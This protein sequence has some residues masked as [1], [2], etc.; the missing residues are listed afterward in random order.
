MS[1]AKEK[2]KEK[3]TKHWFFGAK[4]VI[5]GFVLF[6]LV[7]SLIMPAILYP[8]TTKAQG[9]LGIPVTDPG[10][11]AVEEEKGIWQKAWEA[12]KKAKDEATQ[13]LK[14]VV[15]VALNQSL[16]N[17]LNTLAYDVATW[18]ASGGEGQKPM[19]FT[20]GWG[21]YLKNLADGAA[22]EF[23]EELSGS[24][25]GFNVCNP[26]STNLK[27]R[28]GLGLTETKR[29]KT[30]DCSVTDMIN[31]WSSAVND[32]DFLPKFSD[33]FDPY[34]NDIGIAISMFGK[35][36]EIEADAVEAGT[37]DREEGQGF[38]GKISKIAGKILTPHLLSKEQAAKLTQ[39]DEGEAS[40]VHWGSITLEAVETFIN[41]LAGKMFERLFKEG[42]ATGDSSSDSSGQF[43]GLSL[44]SLRGLLLNSRATTQELYTGEMGAQGFA[45]QERAELRFTD[46][47]QVGVKGQKP[48]DILS[49]LA[50]CPDPEN[51]G[52]EECVIRSDFRLAI[53]KELTLQEAIDQG[54]VNGDAPFGFDE[55]DND[56]IF[57]GYPYRSIVIL[58]T[59]R[60]VPV[61][62]E[63]ASQMINN[64]EIAKTEPTDTFTLNKLIDKFDDSESIFHGL[65]DPNWVLK[66]PE[67]FCRA[68]GFGEK[69]M[70]EELSGGSDGNGDGD[71]EDPQDTLPSR[72]IGRAEYCADFQTC[73]AEDYD[74]SCNYY[75]YCSEEKRVWNL[76]G[77]TCPEE[78]NT[79]RTFQSSSGGIFSYLENSLEYNNCNADNAGCQWYCQA[80]STIDNLW[81]CTYDNEKTLK[82]CTQ[83]GGCTV[84][85]NC[86]VPA[87]QNYCDGSNSVVNLTMGEPCSQTSQWWNGTACALNFSCTIPQNGVSCTKTG[88]ES[89]SNLLANSS[90]ETGV[91]P[92]LPAEADKYLAAD[93][94]TDETGLAYWDLVSGVNER[95]YPPGT[96]INSIRFFS[97]GTD[98]LTSGTSLKSDKLTLPADNYTFS[99]YIY[100]HLNLGTITLS[101]RQSDGSLIVEKDFD[102][103]KINQWQELSADFTISGGEIFVQAKV[104]GSYVSGTAWIDNFQ[105]AKN[106]AATPVVLTLVGDVETD[107]SKLHLDRDAE[108]CEEDASGCSELIRTKANLGT[109]LVPNSSFEDWPNPIDLPSGWQKGEEWV[110][111]SISRE[112]E[113]AVGNF[114]LKLTSD[115]NLNNPRKFETAPLTGLKANT[116]YQVSFYAK[117]A[118]GESITSAEGIWYTEILS[119]HNPENYCSLNPTISCTPSPDSCAAAGRGVC[120]TDYQHLIS[121]GSNSIYFGLSDSWQRIVME[122]ITTRRYGTD[123]K[124]SFTSGSTVI[125]KPLYID[126]VQIEE[127][128]TN[129][130][131]TSNYT[132]YGTT[133][134]TYLKKA[135]DYLNCLGYTYNRPSPYYL[136]KVTK[137]QCAGDNLMWSDACDSSGTYCCHEID[138]P[139]CFDYALYCQED[140][141]GCEAYTPL[142]GGLM[143]PGIVNYDDYCPAECVGYDA[144]K[145]NKTTFENIESIEYFIPAT[146]QQCS[147]SQVG[148]DE[149][150]NLDEVARGGEG[151]E[152]YQYLR[153]CKQPNQSGSNCKNFY[154]WYGSEDTG[155]Q[156]RVYSLVAASD[157]TPE[158]AIW[159]SDA[160]TDTNPATNGWDDWPT[161]WCADTADNNTD[162]LPDCC[163]EADDIITNPFCKEFYDTDGAIHYRIYANT[164]S[165]S[166]DCHP[167]RKTRLGEAD[168][169][170]QNNCIKTKGNWE[171][172]T[173]IYQ[174][175]PS[176]SVTCSSAGAGCREYGGNAGGNVYTAFSDNFED[177][178]TSGWHIGS[179]STEALSVGGHSIK[180]EWS[181]EGNQDDCGTPTGETDNK[182]VVTTWAELYSGSD[183]INCSDSLSVCQTES[184]FNC[185]NPELDKCI[186]QDQENAELCLVNPGENG[187][188]LVNN[189]LDDSGTYLISFWAKSDSGNQTMTL[190]I[191]SDVSGSVIADQIIINPEW[192]YYNF[193]PFTADIAP[194]SRLR[195]M[196]PEG[197]ET[198]LND[199]YIDNVQIKAVQN[200][201][202]AIK[203]SWKTPSSC[204][205]NPWAESGP[206]A[207]PQF[208]LGC[209]QYRDSYSRTH[210]LKSFASLCREEAIGCE[211]LI[212]TF[213]STSPFAEVFNP[214]DVIGQVN[215]EAD[216]TVFLTNRSEF[217]CDAANKGC[218][219][220]GFP[221]ISYATLEPEV[222]GHQTAYLL[223][224]PDQY[225]LTLCAHPEVACDEWQTGDGFSYF[226]DPT[227]KTCEY[228]ALSS[229]SGYGWFKTGSAATTP[230]CPVVQSPVGDPHPGLD[231]G[232]NW[233]AGICP[234]EYHTCTQFIDPPSAD[235]KSLIFNSDF[236][237]SNIDPTR[238]DGWTLI[239]GNY[240]ITQDIRLKQNTLYTLGFTKQAN[241]NLSNFTVEVINCP[242]IFSFDHS[243]TESAENSLKIPEDAYRLDTRSS[244]INNFPN[245]TPYSG[246]FAVPREEVCT[247]RVSLTGGAGLGEL[248]GAV[249]EVTIKETG[250]YYDLANSV[251]RYSCNGVANIANGCVLFNDR[252]S[253]N[254]KIGED[255]TSYLNFDADISG[256]AVNYNLVNN[257]MAVTSCAGNCDSNVILKA[258]PDRVCGQWLSCTSLVPIVDSMGNTKNYCLDLAPCDEMDE[259][260]VCTN[261]VEIKRD[262]L[263]RDY[264]SD[265]EEIKNLSGYST[266]GL[267]L[268]LPISQSIIH[269]LYP[270]AE[271]TEEGGTG[272]IANGDFELAFGGSSEPIG[273]QT[274]SFSTDEGILG[275]GGKSQPA[276][277]EWLDSKFK[278][279]YNPKNT[280][281][282]AGYLRLNT[283][284]EAVSEQID[285]EPNA[286]YILSGL[287]NTIALYHPTKSSKTQILIEL[288]NR[289][290]E[291]V[292]ISGCSTFPD[293]DTG[294]WQY[295]GEN[296][297]TLETDTLEAESGLGWTQLTRKINTGEGVRIR[298]KLSNYTDIPGCIDGWQQTSLIPVVSVFKYR[299][300]LADKCELGGYT[301][302]DNISLRPVLKIK[303]GE[304]LGSD[305]VTRSCRLYPSIEAPACEYYKENNLL[306]GQYGYCVVT[307]PYNPKQC[308]QWWPIDQIKGESFDDYFGGYNDR[309][310][311]DYCTLAF[312]KEIKFSEND[313]LGGLDS[314]VA[315][316]PLASI[317]S[318]VGDTSGNRLQF[319]PFNIDSAF[320]PMMRYPYVESITF[321]GFGGG[322]GSMGGAIFIPFTV[323][324]YKDHFRFKLGGSMLSDIIT[325]ILGDGNG[326]LDT[327][328]GEYLDTLWGSST[329]VTSGGFSWPGLG[330]LFN[331]GISL[332]VS[333]S[334]EWG[335]FG[336]IPVCINLE[337]TGVPIAICI[338]IP[339]TWDIAQSPIINIAE[340]IFNGYLSGAME[341]IV[342]FG[343]LITA[344]IITDEN[345]SLNQQKSD[346]IPDL[347]GDILGAGWSVGNLAGTATD[348][349][350]DA[351]VQ[352]NVWGNFSSHMEIRYCA[353]VVRTVNSAGSNKAYSNRLAR[354]S[355]YLN[356]DQAVP[357]GSYTYYNPFNYYDFLK[358]IEDPLKSYNSSDY[359][360][361]GA[362]VAPANSQY[363]T[364]WD[365]RTDSTYKQPLF[366]EPPRTAFDPP[367]Q[368]RMGEL[369]NVTDYLNRNGLKALFAKSFGV[370]SWEW[371]DST[372]PEQGGEYVEGPFDRTPYNFLPDCSGYDEDNCRIINGCLWSDDQN[373]CQGLAD[374]V[375]LNNTT[376]W[377]LPTNECEDD[378]DRENGVYCLVPPV[379]EPA[380][381]KVNDKTSL[382]IDGSGL[383]KLSFTSDV[384]PD[385]LP[386]VSYAIDWGDGTA[387][388][389]S[390]VALLSRSNENNPF[391]LYHNYDYWKLLRFAS[392]S[393]LPADILS[394][395]EDFCTVKIRVKLRDN[396]NGTTDFIPMAG[397]I[398]VYP[399][400]SF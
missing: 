285:V 343:P 133:N 94:Y 134:L 297:A 29:P 259:S 351:S 6:S 206:V 10:L 250:V 256:L 105:I 369:H 329:G 126:G 336:V 167:L 173:C 353:E 228:K 229:G 308:I 162:G 334:G 123:F 400:A 380:K 169:E 327:P 321:T 360:P 114:S 239:S 56:A 96:S 386:I 76:G 131:V 16:R 382:D 388:T 309:V 166:E 8:I 53:E 243:L 247:L 13:K 354:G 43:S 276:P 204:D 12:A 302:F 249:K 202:Y 272:K 49:K 359:Q 306:Y 50:F 344:K 218:Q 370:W 80:Y 340:S 294:S 213:N 17:M 186:A 190:Q 174:A 341:Y 395:N 383:V 384:D 389:V 227:S 199:F 387:T 47:L 191:V 253:V 283:F 40:K 107:G 138:P 102:I 86:S 193:G 161:Y 7:F 11:T 129:N 66:V 168:T 154:T 212:D 104:S 74:G 98:S 35:Q 326:Y 54:L 219:A 299:Y 139:E 246:R 125:D 152:Y 279:E 39:L 268:G 225:G 378:D 357:F 398:T 339:M 85:G 300:D 230:D 373:A 62:W 391:T 269:G 287:V 38:I 184:D 260:G 282:G 362:V 315:A 232:G 325:G 222:I 248:Q 312:K 374:L 208:M 120:V 188:G 160:V 151:K 317:G 217:R 314:I 201:V 288:L 23:I 127:V 64:E 381:I 34:S 207:A 109:N 130:P 143:I 142:N 111:N 178:E 45:G 284:W 176:Q 338:P 2:I 46:V 89:L 100:S 303:S 238:P 263:R 77:T 141:I 63:I 365:S 1:F 293:D 350:S 240:V 352:I 223:N 310:P 124:L 155:Y 244:G 257:G 159:D 165:C 103:S 397:E 345:T 36:A 157:G 392:S 234:T 316:D 196:G 292:P 163:D 52:A 289:S 99:G 135:P 291:L 185:Y 273:W 372:Q 271:M 97:Y 200:Y 220:V 267:D 61:S 231:D 337:S 145:Q 170:A 379:I 113:G 25:L 60:I 33:I 26:S 241:A 333:E 32:S 37:K 4:K 198:A 27:I 348:D 83:P 136:D 93:W 214:E 363:P 216:K 28:I 91:L 95:T 349:W 65:I 41:T 313:S 164:V 252:S 209:K 224:N 318:T 332:P 358:A 324:M 116:T 233:F 390:G 286:E 342:F 376:D 15:F 177:G 355:G 118:D 19:F 137:T 265:P 377:N 393:S 82:P 21:E 194:L 110:N 322:I 121:V 171:N 20:E 255:D 242:G 75:G 18:L 150:T 22:G 24:W 275:L 330:T 323:T 68:E 84:S 319:I 221:T 73:I 205:T 128:A 58:R 270:Y 149:F 320:E 148:C 368:A 175:I 266:A 3:F 67:T 51:P 189:L 70:F 112:D 245:E 187:C 251:D 158:P 277:R 311:L 115:G 179:I 399:N 346:P 172:N 42:L 347:P 146:A 375:N 9:T 290:G 295:C 261:F 147:A 211:A 106:C 44:S 307:D 31:N 298:I 122:P 226:K 78:Y 331:E 210:N 366:W 304:A 30:P 195:F 296:Q 69:I 394:C 262:D 258:R 71:Y 101:I 72:I 364:G 192:Q 59:H 371:K 237:E 156:L 356:L 281:Q 87:G 153:Q 182:R 55:Y 181:D 119:T 361:F 81:T 197:C 335:G 183:K 236:S 328:S 5:T 254:Y 108:Q 301:L 305:F 79:C 92:S 367:Y 144:Y 90:F 203:G 117:T 140:E 280:I 14:D 88:C 132:D 215:V 274:A 396:W 57:R 235:S 48:Y 385:Q 180:S 264:Y 278:I